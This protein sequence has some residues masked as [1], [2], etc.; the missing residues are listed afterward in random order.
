[1]VKRTI[2]AALAVLLSVCQVLAA[3][4]VPAAWPAGVARAD[5]TDTAQV[6]LYINGQPLQSS[7]QALLTQGRTLVPIR[8]LMEALGAQVQW[9]PQARTVTVTR[10]PGLSV[11]LWIDNRLVC[12]QEPSGVSYDVCDVPPAIIGDRTYVPLRLVAGALGLG[13]EWDDQN[14][15]VLID[16]G[17][18]GQRSRFFD[19]SIEGVRPGQVVADS[20][21]LSLRYGGGVPPGAAQVRYLYLDLSTGEGKIISRTTDIQGAAT[22]TPDLALKGPGILAAAVYDAQGGFLAGAAVDV[23]LQIV[24]RVSLRGLTQGQVMTGDTEMS[25]E[26]N[27]LA[28]GVEYEFTVLESGA[29]TRSTQAGPGEIYTHSPPAG[30]RGDIAVRAIAYDAAGNAYPGAP[31]TIRAEVPAEDD[32]PRVSLRSFTGENVGKV[33]VTLSITRNFDA[34][35][36]QYWARNIANGQTVLLEEKPWGDY[37]WF[38]GPEMAGDWEIYVMVTAPGGKVYASNARA[39]SVSASPSLLL[40]GVGPGQVIT[41]EVKF[42]STA[43]VPLQSVEYIVSNPFN[44]SQRTLGA[45]G[46]TAEDIAW[47]PEKV[48]E[49]ERNLYAVGTLADGREITS[50]VVPVKVYLGQFHTARPVIEKDKF[51]DFVIPMALATQRLNGMSAALQVAQAILETG[52]GQSLPVDR[53]T[54]LFSNN[55]FGIKGTGPAG[56]VLS[57][58]QE[59]YYG[60]LYRTDA[61]FRAYHNVQESWDDHN[62]LLLRMERYQP[63][64]DVMFHSTGGAFALKRCGYATDSAYPD[65]LMTIISQY[66]LDRLDR[67]RL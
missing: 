3:P 47:K 5:A 36:T 29:S 56:S 39:A 51:M 17:G 20:L 54:G 19:I 52:W 1:M 2:A 53:Y 55:L 21:P 62:D 11:K 50:E 34:V 14:R 65:K 15:R 59:E 6:G 16:T 35:T 23:D 57:G 46:D 63:Y 32:T 49:G 33:P 40:S 61:H 25:A 26:V 10:E 38:P 22:L 43:N 28:R 37:V 64:R 48:N 45:S 44:G 7:E 41:G 8:V 31:V 12:Y 42:H 9:E 24:P 67:Q 58:T 27:F 60:T 4:G 30:Q 13:V 18:G 66:G